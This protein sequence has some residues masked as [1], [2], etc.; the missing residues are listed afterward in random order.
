VLAYSVG[1]CCVLEKISDEHGNS[2]MVDVMAGN[3]TNRCLRISLPSIT[4]P[5]TLK[6]I[7]VVFVNEET[8]EEK[9]K[10]IEKWAAFKNLK[11]TDSEAI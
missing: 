6:L 7:R 3:P 1:I 4:A 2:L 9:E 10:F 11:E 5:K 8:A